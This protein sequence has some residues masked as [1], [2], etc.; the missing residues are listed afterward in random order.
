MKKYAFLYVPIIAVVL[1]TL[2]LFT[3]LDNRVNDL[4]MRFLPPLK[5]DRS[6]MLVNIDDASIEQVGTFPW[7]RDVMGDAI[8]F[9]REMGAH[10]AVFD[11]S[12]LDKSPNKV[13]PDYVNKELPAYIDYG[14]GKINDSISKVMDE[15]ENHSLSARDAPEARTQLLAQTVESKETISNAVSHV[16]RDDDQYFAHT[17]KL[18]GNSYLTLT[19]IAPDV[20]VG[21]DRTYEMDPENLKYLEENVALKNVKASDDTKT[22]EFVGIQSAIQMLL[23]QTRSA[24]FVNADPDSDGYRRRVNLVA[25]YNGK[26]Y[27]QL[28][29][30]AMLERFGNPEVDI[31]NRTIIIKHAKI[32]ENGWK[33]IK[34]PRCHDGSVIIK[35]PKNQFE[36]YNHISA[37]D[38]IKS[39]R[40][41]DAFLKNLSSMNDS[42]FFSYWHEDETPL[43]LAHDCQYMREELYDGERPDEGITFEAYRT[44]RQHFFATAGTFLNSGY[45]QQIIS[46][47]GNDKET[48][49]YVRSYFEEC[50]KEYNDLISI[51]NAMS[52]KVKDA[53]CVIGTTAT[54]TTD[55]GLTMYQE[56][57][58]NVGI[59][60]TIANMLLSQ[61]FVDDCNIIWSIL[62]AFALAILTG[63][64]TKKFEMKYSTIAGVGILVGGF[65][66]LLLF[67]VATKVY[68][69]TV[70]PVASVFVTFIALT[71]INFFS[72]AHEKSFLRSAFSRYL[73]NE[74]INQII[75]DPSKLTLGGEKREMTAVFTDIRGF[76]TISEK[77][78]PVE[79]VNLLNKYLTRMCDIILENKGTID[80]FEGDAIIAFFGAPLHMDDHAICACRSAIEMKKA[81]VELNKEALANG[82]SPSPIFTRIGI[83]TGDMVVGNMG[84]AAKMNY[85]IM[86]N[87]VNLASRLEGVNKQYSTRGIMCSE[88]TYNQLNGEFLC[89]RLDRVRVVGINTPIR[90]YEVM[91]EKK[92]TS[93]ELAAYCE[94]WEQAIDLY[95]KREF[96]N[97]RTKFTEL[98][99]E[100]K[101]D[102]VAELYAQRCIDFI[103]QPPEDNWDGVFNL[104]KK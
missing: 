55:Y 16:T 73:S 81:E 95:E 20:I 32:S 72:T 58:P 43:D 13:N 77:L 10:A 56:N 27:G 18:F 85:T 22:P 33:D 29:F 82:E 79:L 99:A 102:H 44:A 48:A 49:D 71:I 100:D 65:A 5:E 14:F 59:Y 64:V 17:L 83:N 9:L 63:C 104:T 51:R 30:V 78:G 101:E 61:D 87:S 8:V 86:G 28:M 35:W 88:D 6:V 25:K 26:Y 4:F 70:V 41:E 69:G 40:L 93:K 97:A 31:T 37:W 74:V 45:D 11:L 90:L 42:G 54:S 67:Y 34:I 3:T 50:R 21:S 66:L 38:A 96:E 19:M 68:I 75:K 80:K 15:F 36:N 84:T 52:Y 46:D 98:L 53:V 23:E 47:L 39:S 57:F 60:P 1:C 24:G 103:T 92:D 62:I 7:T 12:Y 89:R 94:K 76:S 91:E 2:F